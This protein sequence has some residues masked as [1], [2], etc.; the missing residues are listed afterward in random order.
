MIVL[1]VA[2]CAGVAHHGAPKRGG[3]AP[4][5]SHAAIVSDPVLWRIQ[6][7]RL[8]PAAPVI[9]VRC[10]AVQEAAKFPIL[11]PARLPRPVLGWPG[12]PPP[13]YRAD[14]IKDGGVTLGLDIGYGAPWET[15]GDRRHLWRNRPCCFLHFVIQRVEQAVPKAARKASL[16][17][18]EGRL[19]PAGRGPGV[20]FGNHVRFFFAR[21]GIRYVATLHSFGNAAT[22]R[23]LGRIIRTLRPARDLREQPLR[24][25]ER[26]AVA[27]PV[28]ATGLT[29]L[30]ADRAGIWAITDSLG[31]VFA[32]PSYIDSGLLRFGA[33]GR[34]VRH[35]GQFG[36]QHGIAIGFGSVWIA[37]TIA[38]RGVV[39]RV[40]EKSDKLVARIPA[41]TWPRS[42][43]VDRRGVW[44]VDSAPFFRA[45][46]LRLIDPRTNRVVGHSLPLG[47]APAGATAAYGSLWILD[48]SA[49]LLTRV[50]PATGSI[51]A[52][53]PAG[54]SPYA[55]AAAAGSL[56]VTDTASGNVTRI[57]PRTNRRAARIHVDGYPYGIAGDA[58]SIWVARL[59]DHPVAC[60]DIATGRIRSLKG[61]TTDAI[62]VALRQHSL[63]A[64]TSSAILRFPGVCA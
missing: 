10:K 5:H 29:E 47:P 11:C 64:I 17:R 53:I 43:A 42:I 19:L 37:G 2:G 41:G 52:E 61:A 51:M 54:R 45:G 49:D 1:V 9:V 14:P 32:A 63:W 13:P 36:T 23:L 8:E 57:D 21:D 59:G 39:F 7:V 26:N 20:Y 12:R 31:S 58:Q 27:T 22:E 33:S 6:S 16:G 50:D 46:S 4:P 35:G 15:P 48:A 28:A 18:I 24:F 40:D 30:A 60:I 55:V 25:G 3:E 34:L 56:W 44:V 38:N 62:D